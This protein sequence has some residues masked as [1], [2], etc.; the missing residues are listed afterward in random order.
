[1]L[2]S[3][4]VSEAVAATR[5]IWGAPPLQGM[6]TFINPTKVRE[7][8]DFGRCFRKAGWKV[9]GKTKGGLLA[10]RIMPEA[11]PKAVAPRGIQLCLPERLFQP[12]R[13]LGYKKPA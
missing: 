4:L 13:R 2:S 7:K 12:A 8:R 3:R 5:Y 6:V 1:M 11:M 10:L 9:C